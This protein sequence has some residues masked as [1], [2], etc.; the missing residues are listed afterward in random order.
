MSPRG[1][2][3]ECMIKAKGPEGAQ[4]CEV[5]G[6]TAL[7]REGL[8]SQDRKRLHSLEINAARSYKGRAE[9]AS[10]FRGA[11]SVQR[12]CKQRRRCTRTDC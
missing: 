8:N 1:F 7:G 3:G 11:A 9:K 4:A 12:A 10:S 6:L 2:Q 5:K